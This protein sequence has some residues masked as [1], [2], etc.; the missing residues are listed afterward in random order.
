MLDFHAILFRHFHVTFGK[1]IKAMGD[2]EILLIR[3]VTYP[4]PKMMIFKNRKKQ[5]WHQKH[6]V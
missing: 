4:N 2:I 6:K 3:K 5:N 1:S